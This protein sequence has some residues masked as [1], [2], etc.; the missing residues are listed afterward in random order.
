MKL[1][2]S[3]EELL[4]EVVSWL[5]FYPITMW[6]SV[7]HPLEMMRF[8]DAELT[9]SDENE[10][11]ETLSPPLFLLITLLISQGITAAFPSV[12]DSTEAIKALSSESNI[13]IARGVV[14][15]VFPL[16][17]AVTNLIRKPAKLT[18][19]TLRPPFFG[20][21]FVVA[22]FV[23]IAGIALDLALVPNHQGVTA[24]VLTIMVALIW[25]AQAEIRWFKQDLEISTWLA[26]GLFV[27]GFVIAVF[28][29]LLLALAI[30]WSLKNWSA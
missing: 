9:E 24:S 28:T 11:D 16:V 5:V 23:L 7:A 27:R 25:Y 19:N 30:A 1:L 6:R 4:Y 3:L 26:T 8:A 22:P 18:R 21:C 14:F 29:S 15:S 13:L 10:Y 20:Q 2:K 17:M 12:Y